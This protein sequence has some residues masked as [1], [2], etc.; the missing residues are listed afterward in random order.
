MYQYIRMFM[1][2][3]VCVCVCMYMNKNEFLHVFLGVCLG[4]YTFEGDILMTDPISYEY[5]NIAMRNILFPRKKWSMN[6]YK[7]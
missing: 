6:T 1:C 3:C 7:Q 2:V 5:F 4:V